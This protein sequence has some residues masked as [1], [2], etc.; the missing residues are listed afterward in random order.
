MPLL[1]PQLGSPPFPCCPLRLPIVENGY[2]VSV[3]QIVRGA[4]SVLGIATALAA[5]AGQPGAAPAP[6]P[7]AERKALFE[8]PPIRLGADGKPH[9]A[10]CGFRDLRR[11]PCVPFSPLRFLGSFWGVSVDEWQCTTA[12]G[13][14]KEDRVI[15]VS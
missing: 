1:A 3:L 6:P 14:G 2:P 5:P 15:G 12:D 7:I 13:N 8:A 4:D 9:A 10:R 11:G